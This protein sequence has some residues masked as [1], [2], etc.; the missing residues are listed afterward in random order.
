L[1]EFSRQKHDDQT[2]SDT[3]STRTDLPPLTKSDKLGDSIKKTK[4]PQFSLLSFMLWELSDGVQKHAFCSAYL[5][6]KFLSLASLKKQRK[7]SW[8]QIIIVV[9]NT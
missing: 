7:Q 8:V 1:V 3:K 9:M 5:T 6:A 4:K 2:P